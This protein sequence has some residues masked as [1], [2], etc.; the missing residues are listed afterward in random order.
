MHKGEQRFIFYLNQLQTL[1]DKAA[2]QKNPALWLFNNNARTPLFMLEALA[3]LRR[4][5]H[6]LKA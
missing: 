5:M 1:I 6:F 2:K 3:K 4:L